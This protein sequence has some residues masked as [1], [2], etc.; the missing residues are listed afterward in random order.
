MITL[1]SLMASYLELISSF[2][3]AKPKFS[4][5]VNTLATI[6]SYLQIQSAAMPKDFDLD[7]AVGV[8]LDK[9]GEWV[10]RSRNIRTPLPNVYFSWDTP[11]LGWEQGYWRGQ[12]DPVTGL[13]ALADEPYRLLLR[14]KIAANHWDGTL[15][16]AI[17]ILDVLMAGINQDQPSNDGA[18]FFVQDNG[19]MSIAIGLAGRL[20]DAVTIA[21]LLGGYISVH[22]SGVQA[23]YQVVSVNRTPLFGW[24]MN[25]ENVAGW[26]TGSWGTTYL[27][28]ITYPTPDYPLLLGSDGSALYG[29]DGAVFWDATP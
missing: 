13:T 21:L 27:S 3:R 26:G 9:V 28:L 4:G 16:G 19:D 23:T 1:E 12:Y 18:R 7:Y 24:D 17:S 2:F 15:G 29:T 20:P 8:Q 22:A 14:A 10:G 5:H 6:P 11:G 25:N